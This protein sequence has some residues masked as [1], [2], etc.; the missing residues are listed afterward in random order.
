MKKII[1]SIIAVAVLLGGSI[2]AYFYFQQEQP[3]PEAV[4]IEEQA[5][6]L[7]VLPEPPEPVKRQVL[8]TPLENPELPQ[9]ETSDSFMLDALAGLVENKS[10]MSIFRT[11]QLIHHFVATIDNLPNERAPM[12]TMPIAPARGKFIIAENE[13]AMTISPKN[14]ARYALYVKFAE[15]IDP[16]KLVELYVRLYPLFQ[17]SYEE[18]GYPDK[19]FNDRMMVVLANLLAAPEIKEP[20]KL[21]QPKYYYLYADPDLEARSIGQRILM[22]IGSDNEM[23]IKTKLKE[24]KQELILHMHEKEI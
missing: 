11:E 16:K 3:K 2:A 4:Q 10:L 13:G 24:I 9:L 14:K 20:V 5:P 17:Q 22:R 8:D 7:E 12:R 23:I 19:Y 15:E 21:V 1:L 18:L 6:P